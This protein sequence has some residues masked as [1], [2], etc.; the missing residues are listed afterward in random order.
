MSSYI[1]AIVLFSI[2][3]GQRYQNKVTLQTSWET[4]FGKPSSVAMIG[5]AAQSVMQVVLLSNM[6][7]LV[8]S[9][10]YFLSNSILTNMVVAAEYDAY[11]IHR[12]PLRVSWPTGEQRSTRYP[13]LPYRYRVP[14]MVL[15]VALH[16]LVSQSLFFTQVRLFDIDGEVVERWSTTRCGYSLVA[17][18][19]TLIVGA[20]AT[21]SLVGLGLRKYKSS[22]R[23]PIYS[24]IEIS[25]AC[26][27]REDGQDVASGS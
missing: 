22:M 3:S 10:L 26:H 12:K 2:G 7:Q 25:A 19:T 24:S 17:I 13:S 20:I 15:A 8:L 6:P 27:S 21:L 18:L 16:W 1:I 14:F 4:G 9:I 23:L 5:Q 11:V